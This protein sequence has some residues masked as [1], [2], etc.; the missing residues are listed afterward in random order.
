MWLQNKSLLQRHHEEEIT[1]FSSVASLIICRCMCMYAHVCLLLDIF[2][3]VE[4][5]K[6][7]SDADTTS[8]YISFLKI[9]LF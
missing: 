5:Y 7:E 8:L 4:V 2:N 3:I 1:H 9:I 6:L